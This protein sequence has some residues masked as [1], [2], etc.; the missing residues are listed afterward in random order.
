[1]LNVV[2]HF[3]LNLHSHVIVSQI[4]HFEAVSG[5]FRRV[6]WSDSCTPIFISAVSAV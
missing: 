4:K 5:K 2:P 1:M 3:S 6:I